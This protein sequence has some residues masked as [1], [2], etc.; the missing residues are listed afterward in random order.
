MKC[1]N[2]GFISRGKEKFCPYC[3]EPLEE[4]SFLEKQVNLFNWFYISIRSIL[5]ILFSNVFVITLIA[6]IVVNLIIK[7]TTI[8]LYPF[9]FFGL[10]T[11]LL[12]FDNIFV[13]NSS[14]AWAFW[15]G[16]A[17][18]IITSLLL[19][20]SFKGGALFNNSI[21]VWQFNLG[22]FY[23][24]SFLFIMLTSIIYFLVSK[25]F[26]L[27]LMVTGTILMM[28][29]SGVVFGLSFIHAL[30]IPSLPYSRLICDVSFGVIMFAAVDALIFCG[31]RLK[32]KVFRSK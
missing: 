20:A 6:E 4:V 19:A 18:V 7:E 11:F 23:P 12:I 10:M 30:D 13:K 1:K 21:T 5:F 16:N 15:K 9:V 26:D 8:H 32:N 24:I 14:K 28:I 27:V 3:N 31:F 17:I 25:K 29:L 22:Y 2:C